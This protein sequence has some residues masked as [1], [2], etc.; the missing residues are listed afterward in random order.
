MK[1]KWQILFFLF[2]ARLAFGFQFQI[3]GSAAGDLQRN[4]NFSFT[5][6]GTLVGLYMLPG[7]FMSIPIGLLNRKVSDQTLALIGLFAMSIGAF[8]SIAAASFPTIFLARLIAGCGG[9]LLNLMLN[10]M[11]MLWFSGKNLPLAMGL[12]TT[13]FPFGVGLAALTPILLTHQPWQKLNLIAEL[14]SVLGFIVIGF[15]YSSPTKP[16]SAPAVNAAT[17]ARLISSR[18]LALIS[19]SGAAWTIFYSA[20]VVVISFA[21]TSLISLGVDQRLAS[22]SI[23]LL[24]W[25]S[26]PAVSIGGFF[27]SRLSSPLF[28]TVATSLCSSALL[29]LLYSFPDYVVLLAILAGLASGLPVS[30][31]VSLPADAVEKNERGIGIGIFYT[32][33]YVGIACFPVI[34]GALQDATRLPSTP[35]L[36][37]AMLPIPAVALLFAYRSLKK[38]RFA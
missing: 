12:F 30:Y 20:T 3:I 23:S 31:Y 5:Q 2:A 24:S 29:L 36:L 18:S 1:N 14:A 9:V 35:L 13:S 32:W 33:F 11:V 7:I 19:L 8:L 6:I 37:A 34:A 21:A 25:L 28:F 17:T 22:S 38:K 27:L 4:F 16:H 10:K 26:I 15:F